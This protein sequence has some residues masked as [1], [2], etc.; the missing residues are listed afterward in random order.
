MK[1]LTN[2]EIQ[3]IIDQL[4]DYRKL[5]RAVGYDYP[6]E[7][8]DPALVQKITLMSLKLRRMLLNI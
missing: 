6:A 7:R 4:Q 2:A 5:A 1:D 8:L 3:F